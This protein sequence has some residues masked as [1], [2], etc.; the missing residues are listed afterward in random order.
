M[1]I[2]KNKKRKPYL[3]IIIWILLILAF[4]TPIAY[5]FQ[6][7]KLFSSFLYFMKFTSYGWSL[8][9]SFFVGHSIIGH[10]TEKK[11]NWTKN[12]KKANIITLS[13]YIIY[14]ILIAFATAYV[15]GYFVL[16][17]SGESLHVDALFKAFFVIILDLI[18]IAIYY[19]TYLTKYWKKAIENNEELKRENLVA[20]YEVLK[21]KVNPHFLFNSLNTLSSVIERNPE[22]G[23]DFVKKL[24]DIYRYVLE[25][26]DKELVPIDVEMK[27]V[28]DYIFLSK[29][30]F[31]DA[32]TFH[33]AIPENTNIQVVPLGLQ[34]LVEN[35]IKHNIISDDMPLQIYIGME[36]DFI[37]LKNNIQKKNIIIP[38]RKPHGL[39]NLKN[40]YAYH[41]NSLIGITESDEIF[42]VRLPIIKSK[43][44]ELL[45]Y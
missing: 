23:S 8:G 6:G 38:D 12:L 10:Y 40:R 32:L 29:I 43:S 16:E 45:D 30:R 15:F 27:F 25:Q 33:S 14:G 7:K 19:S 37:V 20:K 2:I 5:S 28:E 18:F 42:L 3:E 4:S 11:L 35:A 31:G 24:S 26:S 17:N 22:L 1:R 36:D 21:N 39:E 44:H 9:I 41:T 13:L 34:T